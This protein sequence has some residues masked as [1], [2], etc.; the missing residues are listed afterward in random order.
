MNIVATGR[1]LT[2]V[3]DNGWEYVKRN[4]G[5]HV[6][7]IIP[8][9]I[10]N[11]IIFVSQ[12]R[13]PIQNTAVEFPAGLVGDVRGNES[14]LEAAQSELL[15]ETGY[16]SDKWQVLT[17]GPASA[18]LTDETV[19]MFLALGCEQVTDGGGDDSEIIHIHKIPNG[20]AQEFVHCSESEGLA[21]DP[22]LYCGLYFLKE[23][24]II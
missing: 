16:R 11:H 7:I 1:H 23:N 18:G 19:T 17:S 8:V 21:I 22:K 10:D 14:I 2:L 3:D 5:K 9:T 13:K 6:V 20:A 4:H 15:E 24:N 12:F